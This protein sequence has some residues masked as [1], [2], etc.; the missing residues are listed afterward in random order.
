MVRELKH[1]Q[2]LV[3][4]TLA[5]S[6]GAAG[7]HSGA[8]GVVKERMDAMHDMGDHSKRV[9]DMFKGKTEFEKITLRNAAD[10][11][12]FHAATM[13]DLFPDTDASRTGSET[14]ALPLIWEEK[15]A[16]DNLVKEFETQSVSLRDTIDATD[17]RAVL[18]RAF[19]GATKNCSGCH[20]R[21]RQPTP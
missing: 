9:A 3:F 21:F 6:V 8:V 5:L 15:E 19:F 1:I 2:W 20:K 12:I 11:F 18:K 14:A 17:D 7:S 10:A 13:S 16:F 4:L